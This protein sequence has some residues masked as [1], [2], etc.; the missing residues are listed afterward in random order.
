MPVNVVS[1]CRCV[2]A[3]QV[4]IEGVHTIQQQADVSRRVISECV[5]ALWRQP[6]LSLEALLLKPQMALP[7]CDAAGQPPP[8]ADVAAHTLS[9]IRW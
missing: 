8:P 3:G 1:A 5:A 6:A 7:G 2:C 9:V 4:L